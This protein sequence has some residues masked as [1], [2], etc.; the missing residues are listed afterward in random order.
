MSGT[1]RNP[2]VY[3]M[4]RSVTIPDTVAESNL[5]N[6]DGQEVVAVF[7]PTGTEGATLAIQ[8]S[9][10]NVPANAKAVRNQAG[11]AEVITFTADS[12]NWV[13]PEITR[14]I[15]YFRLVSSL[16][17]AGGAAVITVITRRTA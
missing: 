15:K 13:N 6:I 1:N 4:T 9:T 14:H 11:A 16:V 7:V 5:L 10:T 17:Q 8:G 12:W 2:P 3:A